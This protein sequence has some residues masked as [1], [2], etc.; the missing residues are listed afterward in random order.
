MIKSIRIVLLKVI[1]FSLA[2]SKNDPYS[3]FKKY[4][5]QNMGSIFNISYHQSQYNERLVSEGVICFKSHKKYIFDNNICSCYIEVQQFSI[6]QD[7][8]FNGSSL[9]SFNY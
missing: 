9:R 8:E 5:D 6:S 1:I 7:F 3:N 2:F 4:M